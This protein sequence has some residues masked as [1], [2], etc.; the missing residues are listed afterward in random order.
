MASNWTLGRI[1]EADTAR[2]EQE[3][4]DSSGYV[5]F[6]CDTYTAEK[7]VRAVNSHDALLAACKAALSSFEYEVSQ[8]DPTIALLREAI[9][10]AEEPHA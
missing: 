1:R 6:Q 2:Y 8:G 10:Q 5:V 7:V 3:V 4:C 9:K